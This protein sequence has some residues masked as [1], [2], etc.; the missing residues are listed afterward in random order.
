MRT[1]TKALAAL[2]FAATCM[3]IQCGNPQPKPSVPTHLQELHDDP[4]GTANQVSALPPEDGGAKPAAPVDAGAEA[5]SDATVLSRNQHG[6]C[7]VAVDDANVYWMN[8]GESAVLRVAKRGG[9]SEIAWSSPAPFTAPGFLAVDGKSL[10]FAGTTAKDSFVAQMDK[11]ANK[12]SMLTY[13]IKD[14]VKAFA[15]DASAA[16]YIF[17]VN[18]MRLPRSGGA[19]S[20]IAAMTKDASAVATDGRD[21][22]WSTAG[23][24]TIWRAAARGANV[25]VSGVDKPACLTV[26]DASVWFC[27]GNKVMKAPKAGGAAQAIATADSAVQVLAV[28]AKHVYFASGTGVGRAP[29]DGGASEAFT[30][31]TGAASALALDATSVY[32]AVRGTEA[33][34]FADGAVLKKDK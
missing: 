22:Y 3:T 17:D 2:G 18:V 34:K 6:P 19:P 25:V 8:Q 28:D 14:P 24:G 27:S 7:A 31:T 20:A 23:D 30:K 1:P 13:G 29:K 16:Y 5:Q 12:A 4:L 21:V 33:K 26:D 11:S 9:I 32:V 10:V 15:V